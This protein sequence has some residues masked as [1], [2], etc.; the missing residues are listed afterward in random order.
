MNKIRIRRRSERVRRRGFTGLRQLLS[1][2]ALAP[3]RRFAPGESDHVGRLS[4]HEDQKLPTIPARR[5]ARY[6]CIAAGRN[7]QRPAKRIC[8]A[9]IAP[10]SHCVGSDE[11]GA[12]TGLRHG[13]IRGQPMPANPQR[14]GPSVLHHRR[15]VTG[16]V[17]IRSPVNHRPASTRPVEQ[18]ARTGS[19]GTSHVKRKATGWPTRS[20]MSCRNIGAQPEQP[21]RNT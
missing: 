16:A 10:R 11:K 7:G 20:W 19:E 17:E 9:R 21:G 3:C 18:V 1:E 8:L 4:L 15:A 13:G 5:S 12:A 14:R 2:R 6:G